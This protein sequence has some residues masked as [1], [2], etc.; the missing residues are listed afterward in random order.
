M[1]AELRKYYKDS[2]IK[3]SYLYYLTIWIYV[4]LCDICSRQ[5]AYVFLNQ[6]LMSE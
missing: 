4:W 5:G 2:Q 3:K 6:F 1:I